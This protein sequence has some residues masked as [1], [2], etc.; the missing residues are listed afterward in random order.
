MSN[1]LTKVVS[2]N[3]NIVIQDNDESYQIS[4]I[5]S[6]MNSDNLTSINFGS[7]ENLIKSEYNLN[8]DDELII[9]K[10]SHFIKGINIP[11][12]EYALF[13]NNGSILLDLDICN[14]LSLQ[15]FTPVDIDSN[16]IYKYNLSS[17][18]Y[19]DICSEY[20]SSDEGIDMTIYERKNEF[21]EKNLSLCE[22]NCSFENYNITT[23]K[24]ECKCH[25]S[26][27]LISYNNSLKNKNQELINKVET[28]KKNSNFDVTKCFNLAT[29]KKYLKSNTGFYIILF[30]IFILICIGI[31]FCCKGYRDLSEKI[32]DLIENKFEN[33]NINK[34]TNRIKK[35]NKNKNK[36]NQ[37]KKGI[38]N[39]IKKNKKM[40]K[41]IINNIDNKKQKIYSKNSSINVLTSGNTNNNYNL[42]FNINNK[43][44]YDNDYELNSLS[45]MEALKYDKRELKQYYCSLLFYKQIFI[46]S[47]C[48]YSEYTSAIIKKFIFFLAFAFHYG[49]NALFFNDRIMHQI[50]EDDGKY[51]FLYQ[52]PFIFYSAIISNVA[53]RI[54]LENLIL[55]EKNVLLVKKQ[56]NKNLAIEF[57]KK[58]LKC[59]II[60]YIIFF[61]LCFILLFGFWYYLTCF[62]AVY[63]NTQIHLIKNTLISF[64][65]TF[66]YP[67]LINIIPGILRKDS[68]ESKNLDVSLKVGA[69][70]KSSLNALISNKEYVYKVSK[71]FQIL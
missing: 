45:F 24:V 70:K 37:P 28:E 62:S 64:A 16:S 2:E 31:I 48:N 27:N 55:I 47:F 69:I 25:P 20:S 3:T 56:R 41:I 60:K 15:Y 30:I 32:D 43:V 26:G 18:Y 51:N 12:V 13:N 35:N 67:F 61:V 5:Q 23:S 34:N 71:F 63:S 1:L 7:C 29:S 50:Y 9:F 6:Q 54:I 38:K 44:L 10:I 21:N 68:L 53:L 19:S 65:I 46:F 52:L 59:V 14:N 40:N 39:T 4:T 66:V 58:C 8:P 57:K 22:Y 36:K 49:I 17:D 11:I 42:D 33:K